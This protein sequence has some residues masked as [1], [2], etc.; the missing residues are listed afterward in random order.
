MCLIALTATRPYME[1]EKILTNIYKR[2]DFHNLIDP[3]YDIDHAKR[4]TYTVVSN[5]DDFLK[6][7]TGYGAIIWTSNEQSGHIQAAV[8]CREQ[9]REK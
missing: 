4:P 2:L 9:R 5:I 6:R 1:E 8:H 7:S 3:K